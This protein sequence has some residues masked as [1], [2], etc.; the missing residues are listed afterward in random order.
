MAETLA[1]KAFSYLMLTEDVVPYMSDQDPFSYT[2][3]TASR[4]TSAQFQ[5]IMVDTRASKRSTGGYGQFLALQRQ[6][7]AVQLNIAT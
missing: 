1:N 6:D 3:E 2:T 5:G 7:S 4:Y